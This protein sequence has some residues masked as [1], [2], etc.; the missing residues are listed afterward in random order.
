MTLEIAGS[1]VRAFW[2]IEKTIAKR[3]QETFDGRFSPERR[4][5]F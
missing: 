2:E 5:V 4:S 3:S 1:G